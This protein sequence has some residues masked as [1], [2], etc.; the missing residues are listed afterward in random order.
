MTLR[1]VDAN[2]DP[3][4]DTFEE[5]SDA[6]Q[7]IELMGWEILKESRTRIKVRTGDESAPDEDDDWREVN[8]SD[9]L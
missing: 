8:G 3:L 9:D 2:N 1:L 5:Y 4:D 7:F 6:L